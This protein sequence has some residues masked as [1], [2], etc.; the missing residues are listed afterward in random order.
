MHIVLSQRVD[1]DSSYSDELFK[2]YHYPT[3]YKN[4]LKT[5]DVFVYYQGDRLV[6]EHRY[7][8]GMG[9]IGK[10]LLDDLD[11]SYYAELIECKKFKDKVSIY[12][13]DGYIEQMDFSTVRKSFNP[14]WQSS[15]RPISKK[16][17]EY[18]ISRSGIVENN[19]AGDEDENLQYEWAYSKNSCCIKSRKVTDKIV[20]V[21]DLKEELKWKIKK[22]Y[23]YKQ[24]DAIFEMQQ[25]VNQ[26]TKALYPKSNTDIAQKNVKD[27]REGIISLRDCCKSMQMTFSYKPVLIKAILFHADTDGNV[28]V[29]DIVEF[30]RNFYESRRR[31]GVIIEKGN[32]IF[33][34]GKYTDK[35]AERIII[36]N[37]VKCFENMNILKYHKSSGVI[38]VNA[39]IWKSISKEGKLEIEVVCD[40]RLVQYFKKIGK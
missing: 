3:R 15:V 7:Y 6:R 14:P 22:F 1:I 30:F 35:E 24:N 32:S 17:F 34:K 18:I 21:D 39:N 29:S 23:V 26:I 9:K 8:Y 12:L 28:N 31:D 2:L 5:G 40:E 25:I 37:P 19:N 10:I 36:M 16:A 4:Q 13:E 11:G 38:R 20:S 33:A 27:H